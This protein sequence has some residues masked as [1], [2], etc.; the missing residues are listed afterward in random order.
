MM[1]LWKLSFVQTGF[2]KFNVSE[3]WKAGSLGHGTVVPGHYDI[4]LVLYSR[5]NALLLNT[6]IA[7]CINGMTHQSFSLQ[8]SRQRLYYKKRDFTFGLLISR[9]SL[10]KN[11][12]SKVLL[13]ATTIDQYNLT[14]TTRE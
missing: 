5:G 1:W 6:A 4:D 14:G 13:Q 11:L 9:S 10:K 8:I 12:A 3:I 2:S 7:I